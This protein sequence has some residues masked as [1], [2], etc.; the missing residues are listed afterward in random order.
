[1]VGLQ[2]IDGAKKMHERVRQEIELLRQ[3]NPSLQ[4]GEQLNWVLI[5]DYPLPEIYNKGITSLLWLIPPAYPQTPPDDFFVDG[6]LRLKNGSN[7][8]GFN[9]GPNSSS[10]QAPISGNWGWFSWHPE[11]GKWRPAAEIEKGDNLI[12]FLRSVNICLRG[13]N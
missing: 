2:N 6:D 8:P 4:N 3:K 9:V 7:P 10:G 13:E 11:Q 5:P 12:T 1:M